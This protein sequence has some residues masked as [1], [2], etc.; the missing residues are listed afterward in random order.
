MIARRALFAAAAMALAVGVAGCGGS[1]A[2][3]GGAAPAKIVIGG[4][5]ATSG[6]SAAYG[7]WYS[8]GANLAVKE[9]NDAGGLNG[10]TKIELKIKDTQAQ[11]D[12]AVTALQGLIGEDVRF[13][14]SAFSSQTL[15]LMPIANQRKIPV[16]NGGAQSPLLAETGKFLFND[17]P[18]IY[19][20]SQVL[21]KYLKDEAKLGKA[22]VIH[23][24]DDGGVAAFKSFKESYEGHGGQV[25]AVESGKYQGTDFRSQLTKLKE[26]GADV[27]M[28]GAFG[29]D[30]N[31][32]ISQ[33]REI[34]WDVQIANTSWVAIPDVLANPAAEGLIHTS[35]PFTPTPAFSAAYKAAYGKDATTGYIGNYYDGIK[36]WAAAYE[37]ASAGGTVDPDGQAVMNALHEIKTFDSSYG[38]KLS[39]DDKGVADRPISISRISGGKSSILLDNYAG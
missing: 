28:I 5:W 14:E 31:N 11:A 36:V 35:I 33:V 20:E 1:A 22:A 2:G 25:V 6:P 29:L 39:F 12:T 34:G 17:I 24:S 32:I 30:S 13:V 10:K 21:A 37:K 19:K 7:E 18:L 16:M 9:I 15:A 8:N 3:T 26:S 4:L 23:T 38:S 27:L